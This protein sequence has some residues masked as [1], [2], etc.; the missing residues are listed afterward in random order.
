MDVEYR[1]FEEK[2][3]D[4]FRDMVFCLYDEDPEGLP[5]S[6]EKIRR[7][8]DECI[9]HPDNLRIVLICAEETA[10]AADGA[11]A[12]YGIVVFFWSNEYGGDIAAIDELY[13]KKEY[14]NKQVATDFIKHQM[15][16]YENAVALEVETTESN[17]E[18][19]KLY[20]RLGFKA[21][22]NNRLILRL[23]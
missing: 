18:A 13:V 7:T 10:G 4:A 9:A 12:G 19:M 11:V 2:D 20:S 22:Q 5:I 15:G 23:K 21:S 6:E 3:F 17:R 16:A 8:A 1:H 14:R